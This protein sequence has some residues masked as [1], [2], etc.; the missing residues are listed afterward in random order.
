[1]D[2]LPN[3]TEV[4]QITTVLKALSEP[5]R[6]RIFATL[7][8]GGS[9]NCEL[10][11]SLGLAS[12]LLSHHLRTLEKAGLVHSRRDQ[13]D[14]RWIYYSVDRTAA[15]RWQT[16]FNGFLNPARIQERPLCGPEGQFIPA[17]QVMVTAE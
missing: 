13:V 6:L 12:N 8:N 14:G 9:C 11:E 15:T 5:N 16:W 10:Q 7:M 1:M 17:D 4:G 2:W 3:E